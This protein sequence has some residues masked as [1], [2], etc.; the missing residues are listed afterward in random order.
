M[1]SAAFASGFVARLAI[2]DTVIITGM[3]VRARA[4]GAFVMNIE[5]WMAERGIAEAARVAVARTAR[6][7][8]VTARRGMAL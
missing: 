8:I 7:R 6:A 3:A 4:V 5:P 2:G 1:F